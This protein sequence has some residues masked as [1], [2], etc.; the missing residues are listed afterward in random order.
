MDGYD[1]EADSFSPRHEAS[2]IE[3]FFDLWFVGTCTSHLDALYTILLIISIANLATFTQYHAITN[4]YNFWSYIAFFMIL[5]TSWFHVVC[6]DARFA[7]DS[8]WERACKTVHFCAF[9]AFAL[10][11]YKFM[12]VAKDI[13]SATPHWVREFGH[14]GL[15]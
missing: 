12:P 15:V 10:V 11:G 1:A 2:T 7:S 3:L 6:F 8:V 4:R 5:W 9:A 14:M 13:Q